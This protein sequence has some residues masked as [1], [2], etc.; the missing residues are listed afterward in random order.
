MKRALHLAAVLALGI[1]ATDAMAASY[2]VDPVHSSAVFKLRHNDV[3]NFY[4][5]ITGPEGTIEYD[6]AKPEASTFNF[7]LK[8]ANIDTA[9]AA[10]DNHLKSPTYF[11]A[12][13]YPT[14]SFKSTAVKKGDGNSMEVT[15]DLTI[16]GVK[17]SVTV[18]MEKTGETSAGG[19]PLVG[20]ES[21]FKI[22]RSDFGMTEGG[23]VVGDE[24]TIMVAFEAGGK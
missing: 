19:K 13:E 16:H 9:N 18:T 4:G 20:F 7:T 15:G 2:A 8:A 11:N 12:A 10:R 24:V 6:A 3:S 1:S 23:N 5:R 21:T 22:K 17:K 14:L